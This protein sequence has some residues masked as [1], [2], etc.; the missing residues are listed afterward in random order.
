MLE[1]ARNKIID[2]PRA[3]RSRTLDFSDPPPLCGSHE[4]SDGLVHYS[5][6]ARKGNPRPPQFRTIQVYPKDVLMLQRQPERAVDCPG[7]FRGGAHARRKT[8]RVDSP[9]RRGVAAWPL[10]AR[11]EQSA[12][13]R[14]STRDCHFPDCALHHAA[15]RVRHHVGPPRHSD[16]TRW[17]RSWYER[18]CMRAHAVFASVETG[19]ARP[20]GRRVRAWQASRPTS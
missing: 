13:H 1:N 11:A 14:L 12:M 20:V 5:T 9:A 16:P 19:G 8:A 7:G 4:P 17:L 3:L 15:S 10:A 18:V 2:R 6:L